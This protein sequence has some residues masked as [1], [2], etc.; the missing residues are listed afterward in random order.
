LRHKNEMVIYEAAK[1]ICHLPGVEG[2]SLLP[3]L[4]HSLPPSVLC[5]TTHIISLSS[6]PSLPPSFLHFLARD[7]GPA[8][9]VLQLFLASPRPAF[10]FCAMRTLS[11]VALRY[12]TSLP[13]SFPPSLPPSL[14]SPSAPSAI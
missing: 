8:I 12:V 6:S 3:S 2:T 5:T 14:P 1:A 13:P 11:E 9:T 4:P 10:R 7:L